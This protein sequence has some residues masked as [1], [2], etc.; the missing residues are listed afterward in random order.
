MYNMYPPPMWGMPPPNDDQFKRGMELAYRLSQREDREKERKK[1]IER[2]SRDEDRHRAALT[3]K[4]FWLYIEV[5][6]FG[7]IA[8]PFVVPIY[9]NLLTMAAK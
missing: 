4:R 9:N 6:I 3:Q 1:H 8:Q 2:K 7:I 5:F